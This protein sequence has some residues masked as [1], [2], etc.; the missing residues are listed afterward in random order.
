MCSLTLTSIG[1]SVLDREGG[2]EKEW[3]KVE[4]NA[5]GNG[6]REWSPPCGYRRA[7]PA[8]RH[9]SQVCLGVLFHLILI[10]VVAGIVE[11]AGDKVCSDLFPHESRDLFRP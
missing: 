6:L 2:R 4:G 9:V 1:D 8:A 5:N 10:R 3:L 7:G 11:K